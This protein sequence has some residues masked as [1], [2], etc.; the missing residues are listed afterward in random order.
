[1]NQYTSSLW[2]KTSQDF[3]EPDGFPGGSDGKESACDTK[4][5]GSIPGSGTS[6]GEGN[7]NPL[8][9]SCLENPMDREACGLQPMGSQRVRHDWKTNNGIKDVK[10]LTLYLALESAY[11]DTRVSAV[12]GDIPLL[13]SGVGAQ[14]RRQPLVMFIEVRTRPPCGRKHR[15]LKGPSIWGSFAKAHSLAIEKG[16]NQ[17]QNH[18]RHRWMGVVGGLR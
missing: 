14:R 8:Q 1:M 3:E 16:A 11:S 12:P 2:L 18:W 10:C 6:S 7:G 9:Y 5:P 4:D 17:M 15:H 13:L